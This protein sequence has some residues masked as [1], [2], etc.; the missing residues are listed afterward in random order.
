[1]DELEGGERVFAELLLN[2]I[3]E[4]ILGES[5]QCH[6]SDHD[7]PN[8]RGYDLLNLLMLIVL[9][10]LDILDL[11]EL[12]PLLLEILSAEIGRYCQA[13]LDQAIDDHLHLLLV[14]DVVVGRTLT[15]VLLQHF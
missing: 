12:R 10:V 14:D 9:T 7:L 15:H 13:G 11:L 5:L 3:D 8:P 6:M 4:F 2:L 1:M